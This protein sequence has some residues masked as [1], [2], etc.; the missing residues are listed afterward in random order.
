MASGSGASVVVATEVGASVVAELLSLE[1]ATRVMTVA[2]ATDV[3]NKRR[4][5]NDIGSSPG[6]SFDLRGSISGT[7]VSW[8]KKRS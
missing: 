8:L 6:N 3:A 7:M 5:A 1:Q 4:T 2:N